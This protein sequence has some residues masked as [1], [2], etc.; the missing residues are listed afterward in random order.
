MDIA[1]KIRKKRKE[2][3]LTQKELAEKAGI[4]WQTISYAERDRA[5][6]MKTLEKI[7]NVLGMN[8]Y[9]TD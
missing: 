7:I 9:V 4:A 3:G 6:N 1:N 5:I 8:L 2:M